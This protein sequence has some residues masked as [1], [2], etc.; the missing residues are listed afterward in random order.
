MIAN[1]TRA[2]MIQKWASWGLVSTDTV[3]RSSFKRARRRAAAPARASISAVMADEP[4][5]RAIIASAVSTAIECTCPMASSRAAAI[6]ASASAKPLASRPASSARCLAAT[7]LASALASAASFWAR[8]RAR[9]ISSGRRPGLGL[10]LFLQP[11][12]LG[13]VAGD[14]RL[15]FGDR[16]RRP[17]ARTPAKQHVHDGEDDQHPHHLARPLRQVELRQAAGP[18]RPRLVAGSAMVGL[19]PSRTG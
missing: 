2:I 18:A 19:R 8:S 10:G 14:L 4:V 13:D 15:A 9:A 6:R 7:D 1:T 12:R 3:S 17:A 16:H 11:A 5:R